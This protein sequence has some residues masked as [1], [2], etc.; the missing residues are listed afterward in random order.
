MDVDFIV[1]GSGIAGLSAAVEAAERG[2]R[3]TVL[4]GSPTIGG[5]SVMSGAAC[6]LDDMSLSSS[7]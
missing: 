6:C 5:A 7:S 1:I 2:A 4:E 3:V